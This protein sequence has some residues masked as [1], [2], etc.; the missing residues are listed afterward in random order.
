M[1]DRPKGYLES[2]VKRV[3]DNYILG[4][5]TPPANKPM[6]PYRVARFVMA[7]IAHTRDTTGKAIDLEA[8]MGEQHAQV[9][10][11][12]ALGAWQPPDDE[13]VRVSP[14]AVTSMLKRWERIGFAECTERPF[15]FA[16][17]TESATVID[18]DEMKAMHRES[19][20]AAAKSAPSIDVPEIGELEEG[21]EKSPTSSAPPPAQT[22]SG[23]QFR[24]T[25]PLEFN[26]TVNRVAAPV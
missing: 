10:T 7:D 17:Y 8:A 13:Y 26:Q 23:I 24:Q 2:L 15:A 16:G 5:I 14:G 20:S 21:T 22:S 25:P 6:T 3:L 1:A 9:I 4:T 11:G 18:L 12:L 19:R